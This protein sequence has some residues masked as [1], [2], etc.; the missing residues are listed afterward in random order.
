[1]G[2]M[3]RFLEQQISEY[4]RINGLDEAEV[5]QDDKLYAKAVEF[6][7]RKLKE[8]ANGTKR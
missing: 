7:D 8:Q 4:C 6:A 2:M 3:K 5:Y 1:M